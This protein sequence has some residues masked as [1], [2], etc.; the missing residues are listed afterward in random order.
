MPLTVYTIGHSTRSIEAFV[1]LLREHGVTRTVDVRRYPVSRRHPH[2][3]GD[4]LAA[5]LA[6]RG[7]DYQHLPDL[8]GRRAPSADSPNTAWRNAS[9]R[10][11]ADY[12]AT[13]EF[14]SALRALRALASERPTAIMCAEAVYWRCHRRLIADALVAGGEQVLHLGSRAAAEPHPLHPD[15][16]TD[17][18]GVLVYPA[19]GAPQAGLFDDAT[20]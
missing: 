9:F 15:A 13:P 17:A 6:E 4:A 7:I 14:A 10:A 16:R 19:G 18:G 3:A 8:G 2:F 11:Y 12:M 20:R 5:S 1:A